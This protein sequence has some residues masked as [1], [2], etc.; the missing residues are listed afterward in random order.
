[1]VDRENDGIGYEAPIPLTSVVVD[2][3]PGEMTT[4]VENVDVLQRLSDGSVLITVP[5]Y[6]P[7]TEGVAALASQGVGFVEIAGNRTV[8]LVSVLA[9]RVWVPSS[10][11]GDVMFTQPILTQP[12]R[13]R[14]VLVVPVASL[15]QT[16]NTLSGSS[17]EIE[18]VYDY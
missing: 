13:I 4:S 16:L 3:L 12:D 1:M 5:R 6:A 15:A 18:H 10:N 2:K 9:P 11:M 7:F 14:W 8:I 17:I